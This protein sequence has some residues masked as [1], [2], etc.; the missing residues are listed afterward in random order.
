MSAAFIHPELLKR[1]Q[2]HGAHRP[3]ALKSMAEVMSASL[4]VDWLVKDYLERGSLAVL[5]GEPES[6]KSLVMLDLLLHIAAGRDW[7]G[8][9]VERGPVVYICGE[10]HAGLRR[11][12]AAWAHRYQAFDLPVFISEQPAALLDDESA[13]AVR[14]AIDRLA[15]EHG[16]P[17]AIGVDTVQRNYGPGDENA[18]G[19]M[20]RW[21]AGVDALRLD[22]GATVLAAHHTGQADKSRARGSIVLKAS[23]DVEYK[24]TRR[25]NTFTVECSKAKD[26]ERP[27]VRHFVKRLVEL[28][29]RDETGEPLVGPIIE[30]TGAPA[31]EPEPDRPLTRTER[32]VL[33]ALSELLGD[34]ATRR[35]PDREALDG[36]CRP[37]QYVVTLS[38]WRARA[39]FRGVSD[40]DQAARQKAFRRACSGLADKRRVVV[41]GDLVWLA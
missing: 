18:T 4:S 23:A 9:A 19:D 12:L 32:L 33:E 14:Q 7:H 36:G 21:V 22:Y 39:Y 20:T 10:G 34:P 31:A 40:G 35:L 37:G 41:G 15:A 13:A 17:L 5:F 27:P 26:F 29:W 1:A 38:D 30:P 2:A 16:K 25:D 8:H 6:G 28:P 3:F 11:R 24:V